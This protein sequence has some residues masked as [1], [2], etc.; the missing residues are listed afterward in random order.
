MAQ[1]PDF[2]KPGTGTVGSAAMK[3]KTQNSAVFTTTGTVS[4][5]GKGSVEE[6]FS[7]LN[8]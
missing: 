1:L 3:L 4:Q 8:S 5:P 7:I 2:L 6:K